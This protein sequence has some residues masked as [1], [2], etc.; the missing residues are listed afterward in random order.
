MSSPF[1]VWMNIPVASNGDIQFLPTVCKP[2]DY[3]LLRA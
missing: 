1:N 2:G 3:L